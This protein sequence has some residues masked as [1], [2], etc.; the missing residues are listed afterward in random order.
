VHVQGHQPSLKRQST[1][2]VIWSNTYN[3]LVGGLF[4]KLGHK[5]T[6]E[7]EKLFQSEGLLTS[8]ND[9]SKD[10]SPQEDP[11][12]RQLTWD[13]G[14]WHGRC[15]CFSVCWSMLVFQ[16]WNNHMGI[17]TFRSNLFYRLSC[18]NETYHVKL[19]G[20]KKSL[21]SPTHGEVIRCRF[22]TL[23]VLG[24]ILLTSSKAVQDSGSH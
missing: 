17:A 2:L 18:N 23:M 13:N 24:I 4:R 1:N 10:C 19:H 15:W 8:E 20:S 14:W 21:A 7:R 11:L 3:E 12:L 6:L 22:P 5:R 16:P 9:S